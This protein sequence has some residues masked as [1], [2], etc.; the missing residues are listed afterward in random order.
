MACYAI[1]AVRPFISLDEIKMIYFSYVH[2]F[3]SYGIIFWSNF[4]L[5]GSI[6]KIQ[7]RII[8]IIT[9]AGRWD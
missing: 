8:R 5:S 3:I 9:N 7:K 1:R 4:H 6:F 2:S